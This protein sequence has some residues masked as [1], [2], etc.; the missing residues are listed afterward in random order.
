MLS[1]ILRSKRAV[2][3]NIQ[4]MRAFNQLRKML[5]THKDLKHKIETMEKKYD[6]QF[7]IVFEAITQLIE[8]DEKPKKKVGYIKES[9]AK[10]GKSRR[11]N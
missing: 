8:E 3:V 11:K 1:S 5:V 10:Y 2:Q 4:I 7:R 6:E 9:Q